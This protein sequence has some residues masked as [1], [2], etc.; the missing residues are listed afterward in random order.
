MGAPLKR[1][2]ATP[3]PAPTAAA[4]REDA[5]MTAAIF[6]ISLNLLLVGSLAIRAR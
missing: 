5:A 1:G 2:R 3:T 4:I 6:V